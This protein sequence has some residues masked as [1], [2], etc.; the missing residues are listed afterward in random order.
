MADRHVGQPVALDRFHLAQQGIQ[1]VLGGHAAVD[2][3]EDHADLHVDLSGR[4]R[5][6]FPIICIDSLEDA[7]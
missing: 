2:V 6:S 3:T 1:M 7:G 4:G 5:V